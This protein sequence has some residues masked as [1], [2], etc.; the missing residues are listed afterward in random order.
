MGPRGPGFRLWPFG[1]ELDKVGRAVGGGA[2][3]GRNYGIP[4]AQRHPHRILAFTR[5]PFSLCV[6]EAR[7]AVLVM[8]ENLWGWGAAGP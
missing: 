2:S 3:S 6:G 4:R 5:S 7:G 8:L 1:A